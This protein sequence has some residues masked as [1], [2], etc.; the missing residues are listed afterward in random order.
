MRLNHAR[1]A[2]SDVA[3]NRT[4]F[5]TYFGLRCVVDRNDVP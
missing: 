5:E 4:F 2:V 1:V 3:A